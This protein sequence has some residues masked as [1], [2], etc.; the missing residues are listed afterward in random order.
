MYDLTHIPTALSQW[1]LNAT[2]ASSF[3]FPSF[4]RNFTGASW[5]PEHVINKLRSLP[6]IAHFS[7]YGDVPIFIW[8]QVVHA[9][10]MRMLLFWSTINLFLLVLRPLNSPAIA[11]LSTSTFYITL[12][13]LGVFYTPEF[14]LISLLL[15]GL[16]RACT[17]R[18]EATG[19]DE[20]EHVGTRNS[21]LL[22]EPFIT[23]TLD[24]QKF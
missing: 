14:M 20:T 1:A 10:M 5:K 16:W 21:I 17:S 12:G 13:V 3:H 7:S 11:K 15:A 4:P 24:V 23:E 8:V 19:A 6:L 9:Y 22:Q 18:A 2:N